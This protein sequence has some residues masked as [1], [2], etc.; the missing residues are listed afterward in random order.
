MS[1][2][3][4]SRWRFYL[5][6]PP[7]T[8]VRLAEGD[9]AAGRRLPFPILLLL[10]Q[11]HPVLALGEGP[12]RGQP[13]DLTGLRHVEDEDTARGQGVVDAAEEPI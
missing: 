10:D 4:Y 3:P 6:R 7:I 13:L 8:F 9:D 12:G 5:V 2:A 11:H 1:A